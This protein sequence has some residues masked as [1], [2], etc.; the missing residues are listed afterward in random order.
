MNRT[1]LSLAFV[2]AM[3]AGFTADGRAGDTGQ[4]IK[5]ASGDYKDCKA[6]CKD[7]FQEAKD[8]CIN[9]DHD[10]VDACR[11]VRADCRDATG[12]DDMIKACNATR[13]QAIQ[14][15]KQA[16]PNDPG[17][18][19]TCIDDAQVN[20][21]VCRLGVRKSTKSAL[22]ACRKGFKSCVVACPAGVGTGEVPSCCRNM[23]L[24]STRAASATA[25]KASRS[26]RT[27][28]GT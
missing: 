25:E 3:I 8:A 10:C 5:G 17:S 26:T 2:A 18:R 13:D 22:N 14:N 4:C 9:R 21:F 7:D 12:F 1:M 19:D 16:Y 11:E 6:G 27:R 23:L 20:E 24:P 28:A 15:C